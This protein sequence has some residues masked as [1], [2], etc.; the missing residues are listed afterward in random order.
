MKKQV[1]RV[2][3]APGPGEQALERVKAAWRVQ[4]GERLPASRPV[5]QALTRGRPWTWAEVTAWIAR[6]RGQ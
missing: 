4:S 1:I 5:K 2:R 3:L 6:Y